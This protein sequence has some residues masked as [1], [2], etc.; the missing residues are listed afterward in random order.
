MNELLCGSL[1]T[2]K[3]VDI[4]HGGRRRFILATTEEQNGVRLLRG[5]IDPCRYPFHD[6]HFVRSLRCHVPELRVRLHCR[7]IC[8]PLPHHKKSLLATVGCSPTRFR[9]E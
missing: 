7:R 8:V 5:E 2:M 6:K 3:S 1:R 9:G 4:N